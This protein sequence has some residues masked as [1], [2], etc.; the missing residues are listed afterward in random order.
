MLITTYKAVP[1][2]GLGY[3]W[4]CLSPIVSANRTCSK[5]SRDMLQISSFK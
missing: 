4:E 1:G 3:L 5:D 2:A